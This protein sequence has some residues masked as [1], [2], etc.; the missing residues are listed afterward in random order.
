MHLTH[1][2]VIF[3]MWKK[4]RFNIFVFLKTKALFCQKK[5]KRQRP[6]SI[7]Y[8]IIKVGRCLDGLDHI[9]KCTIA[10]RKNKRQCDQ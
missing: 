10:T 4:K 8:V 6:Y 3:L 2:T 7:I 5:K 9:Y 1:K